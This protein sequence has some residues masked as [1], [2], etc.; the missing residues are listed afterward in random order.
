M[1]ETEGDMN[2]LKNIPCSWIGRIN[3]VKMTILSKPIYRFNAI[4]IKIPVMVF[5]R[6]RT[7]N[8]K[9]YM[10]TQKTLKSKN[11]LEKKE[12]IWRYAISLFQTILQS[13]SNQNYIVIH[14]SRHMDQWNRVENPKIDPCLYGQLI[15][16]IR[17]KNI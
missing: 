5:N 9:T 1:K 14:K 17:D 7:N 12:Q 15:H 3:T 8:S 16:N 6:V 4:S 13:Y 10:K 11:N 2:K